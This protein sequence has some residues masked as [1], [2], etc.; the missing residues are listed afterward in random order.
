[1]MSSIQ[2]Y[3]GMIGS[4][5]SD[6]NIIHITFETR[7]DSIKKK[8]IINYVLIFFYFEHLPLLERSSSSYI[9]TIFK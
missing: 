5:V 6:S 9:L 2:L 3:F 7:H 1:M 4:V 8:I